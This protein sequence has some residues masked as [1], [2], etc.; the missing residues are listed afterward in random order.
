V[1]DPFAVFAA[2]PGKHEVLKML[3]AELY[4]CLARLDEDAP[5]RVVLCVLGSCPATQPRPVAVG[6]IQR[7]GHPACRAHIAKLADRPGGWPLR[8]E[9][10]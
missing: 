3:W 7:R 5:P 6:R 8:V 4:N 10:S 2:D 1:G 9:E